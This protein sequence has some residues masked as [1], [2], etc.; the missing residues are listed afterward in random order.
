MNRA[1]VAIRIYTSVAFRYRQ[2]STLLDQLPAERA[3]AYT[4]TFSH[5][6]DADE[7]RTA[8]SVILSPTAILKQPDETFS[9]PGYGTGLTWKTLI[10]SSKTPTDTLTS[11]IAT[12]APRS[13]FLCV[14]QHRQAEL[15]HIIQGEGI[16]EVDGLEHRVE[17]GSVVFIPGNA[18]HGIRNSSETDELVWLYVFAADDFSEV[19]YRFREDRKATGRADGPNVESSS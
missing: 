13:G 7:T 8:K 17:K 19:K 3:P 2:P 10:S 5:M 18:E 14:H 12:C 1:R 4:S 9:E 16:V 11:G 6:S 15:Y